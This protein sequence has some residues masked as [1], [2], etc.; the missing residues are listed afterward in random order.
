VHWLKQIFKEKIISII[1]DGLSTILI[2]LISP[3]MII[4][5]RYIWVFLIRVNPRNIYKYSH[6]IIS[7]TLFLLGIKVRFSGKF[8]PEAK[9]MIF[10]HTSPLDYFLIPLSLPTRPYNIVA[11]IN[12]KNNKATLEDKVVSWFIGDIIKHLL[13]PLDRD[14]N[15]SRIR[16]YR[17]VLKEIQNERIVAISP[18]SGRV[19]KKEVNKGSLLKPEFSDSAFRAAFDNNH[20]MQIAVFDWPVIWRGKD[21]D[22][23]G[24]HPTTIKISY[25]TVRPNEFASAEHMK[26]YCYGVIEEKLASSK[27]VRR[28]MKTEY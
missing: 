5:L 8:C 27:N 28:F 7:I 1:L 20:I 3:T 24:I 4:V 19:S 14:N 15:T 23:F 6:V 25:I 16:A 17:R 26:R 18:E 13:I 12:L 9:V 10:N 11:G 21:D 22:R 2:A